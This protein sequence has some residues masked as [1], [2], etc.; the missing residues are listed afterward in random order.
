MQAVGMVAAAAG[1]VPATSKADGAE[2]RLANPATSLDDSFGPVRAWVNTGGASGDPKP[3]SGGLGRAGVWLIT[4]I[5]KARISGNY[6]QTPFFNISTGMPIV[7]PRVPS[8]AERESV[9][10][11]VR[12][13]PARQ[14]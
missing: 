12:P 2:H 4:T 9:M 13:A 1:P 7:S 3:W 11:A 14:L 5:L 6:G 8:S 10:N